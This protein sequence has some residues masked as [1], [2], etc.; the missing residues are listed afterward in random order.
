MFSSLD[1][2]PRKRVG[3]DKTRPPLVNFPLK[4]R[5]REAPLLLLFAGALSLRNW[6]KIPL[7]NWNQKEKYPTSCVEMAATGMVYIASGFN[8]GERVRRIGAA[9]SVPSMLNGEDDPSLSN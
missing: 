7:S 6:G 5:E 2:E 4:P 3:V 9:Q 8:A 1:F